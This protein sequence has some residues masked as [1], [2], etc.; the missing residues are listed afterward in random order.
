M[1]LGRRK[2]DDSPD[3]VG[4]VGDDAGSAVLFKNHLHQVKAKAA[5]AGPSVPGALSR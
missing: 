1:L 5:A 2:E 4:R 3:A